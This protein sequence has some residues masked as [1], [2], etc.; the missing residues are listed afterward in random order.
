MTQNRARRHFGVRD[1][2]PIGVGVDLSPAAIGESQLN[3]LTSHWHGAGP[4][5]GAPFVPFEGGVEVGDWDD[6]QKVAYGTSFRDPDA[7]EN[8]W[9]ATCG[10]SF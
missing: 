1:A 5:P 6:S 9:R 8:P 10:S 7:S 4:V 3:E 2:S